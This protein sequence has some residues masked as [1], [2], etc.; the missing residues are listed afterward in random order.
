MKIIKLILVLGLVLLM[1]TGCSNIQESSKDEA[2]FVVQNL[3]DF[4]EFVQYLSVKTAGNINPAPSAPTVHQSDPP[5]QFQKDDVSCVHEIIYKTKSGSFK[6]LLLNDN[7][8]PKITSM[9]EFR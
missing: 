1:I 8:P 4:Q 3:P 6:L 9:K 5:M 7:R 2:K